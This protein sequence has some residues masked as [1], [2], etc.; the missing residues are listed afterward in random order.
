M[1]IVSWN[2][3]GIRA[4]ATK[5]LRR[6]MDRSGAD[7]VALQ[8]TRATA[9]QYPTGFKR[10][11]AWHRDLVAADKKGYSGVATFSRQPADDRWASLNDA[12]F[13]A[14]GRVLFSRFGDLLVVNAY[15]PNGSGSNRDH[16]RIPFKL[17]FT[18]RVFDVLETERA[19]GRPILVM[20]DYNTAHRAIDLAR[21]K[22]NR[23]TSGFTPTECDAFQAILDRGWTDTFRHVHGDVEGVY[24]W[25]SQR[26]GVRERNIG[27]RIDYILASGGAL[28][29]VRDAFV[30]TDVKGSDHCP[31]GVELDL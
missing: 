27:W 20:G 22:T 19:A 2:I 29:L 10:L 1:R 3:N 7:V 9:D 14:E 21:P 13:D 15:F 26:F 24:S 31:I 6:W 16:S 4:A 25:W 5:G 30:W 17:A 11:R 8:E 18:D 28:P 12:A 23:K